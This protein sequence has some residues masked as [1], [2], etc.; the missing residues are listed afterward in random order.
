MTKEEIQQAIAQLEAQRDQALM[1][2][3]GING[4]LSVYRALLAAADAPAIVQ[5][6]MK[7]E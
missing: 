6:E 7:E 2:L 1:N 4:A 3:G 5:Q